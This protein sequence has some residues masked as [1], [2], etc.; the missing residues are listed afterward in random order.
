VS[1]LVPVLNPVL[2]PI[3]REI[4][5]HCCVALRKYS[6]IFVVSESAEISELK[7][8]YEHAD[9]ITFNE[10]YF[11]SRRTLASLFL[12]EGFYERFSWCDFL[13]IHELN[14]WIVKDELHYWCKQGYDFLKADP[15]GD[16]GFMNDLARLRGL[17]LDQKRVMDVGF[18]DNG[19]FLCHIE[20]FVK[21][22]K[23]KKKEAYEYR[24][25]PD[26]VN[27]DALF[28]ELEPNRFLPN[29][30]RPTPIVQKRFSRNISQKTPEPNTD[31]E[32][33]SFGLTGVDATNIQ[34]LPYF[35]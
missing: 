13:L 4:L 27:V 11:E 15:E 5:D 6:F 24:H 23:R 8:S 12:M 20:R 2:T 17:S 25:H 7:N 21:T 22:L 3:E 26:F 10:K 16:S 35:G 33:W 14:S 18:N 1:V 9:F 31:R 32:M 34:G 29:L 30:R 19:L 28:W